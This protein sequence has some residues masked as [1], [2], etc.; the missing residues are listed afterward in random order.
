[1]HLPGGRRREGLRKASSIKAGGRLRGH[2][3]HE[4]DGVTSRHL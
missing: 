1:M 2:D 4:V 3:R